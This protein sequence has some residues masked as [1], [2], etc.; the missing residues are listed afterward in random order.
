MPSPTILTLLHKE[1]KKR[2]FFKGTVYKYPIQQAN[3]EFQQ[4]LVISKLCG[5]PCP[6]NWP[7]VINLPHF[8]NIKQNKKQYRRCLRE[9]FSQ[10]M[11]E[12]ALELLDR[13]LSLDPS[14]RISA[15]DALN[16]DWLRTVEPDK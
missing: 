15:S 8:N 14:K 12:P 11:P 5:S 6:A 10:L 3:E 7:E 13:M 2:V 9:Q 16:C 4:L 1:A